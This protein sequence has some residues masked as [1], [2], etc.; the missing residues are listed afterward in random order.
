MF[1]H[2]VGSTNQPAST[3]ASKVVVVVVVEEEEEEIRICAMKTTVTEKD[4]KIPV[5]SKTLRDCVIH[6]RVVQPTCYP[7]PY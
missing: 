2:H 7:T 5:K 3:H 1:L 4:V 6:C